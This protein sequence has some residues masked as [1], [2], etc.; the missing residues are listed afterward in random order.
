[1]KRVRAKRVPWAVPALIMSIFSLFMFFMD[2]AHAASVGEP[3]L[4]VTTTETRVPLDL[5]KLWNFDKQAGGQPP[6]GFSLHTV[7]GGEIMSWVVEQDSRSPSAPNIVRPSA[8]CPSENCLQI[9]LADALRFDYFDLVVRIR[10]GEDTGNA[11]GAAGLIFGARD[12]RNF[13]AAT[14]DRSGQ[15]MEVLRMQDGQAV[16]LGQTEIHSR[17]EEWHSMR[18]R[19]NT[20]MSKEYIEVFFNGLQVFSI[21]DQ[22]FRTGQIGLITRGAAV[23]SFDNL[24]TAPLYSQRTLSSPAPY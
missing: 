6:E 15:Y 21:E 24:T 1:M 16:S 20:I 10:L 3:T 11:K 12:E 9:L 4:P 8:A 14:I 23:A 7:N 17:K 18:V 22:T 13:Y 19:R 2:C 5:F